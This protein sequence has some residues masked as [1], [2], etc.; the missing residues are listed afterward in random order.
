VSDHPGP[1]PG[2]PRSTCREAPRIETERLVLRA[3]RK[4]DFRRWHAIMQQPEVHRHFG[5]AP[6]G[7]EELWRRMSAA[8][9]GWCLNGFGTWAVDRKS[10][11]QLIGNVGIFTAWRDLDPQFGEEPEMGWIFSAEVHGQGI[12]LEA[13]R[14]ALGWI[15]A[16]LQ[17]T[18]IWAIVAPA[19]EPSIRLGKRLGFERL[20]LTSYND[21][22]TLV[23]KRTAWLVGTA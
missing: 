6:I 1:G 17:P 19:N 4:D 8:V 2:S 15:E 3:W 23:L 10:D 12:A 5:P 14:A 18:P 22:P 13:C 11:G 7:L 21:E 16:S 9:G 20:H